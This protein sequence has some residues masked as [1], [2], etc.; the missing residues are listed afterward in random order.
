MFTGPPYLEHMNKVLF[1]LSNMR[2][3]H[4]SQVGV[5]DDDEESEIMLEILAQVSCFFLFDVHSDF[6]RLEFWREDL[7]DEAHLC[8][9]PEK[10]NNLWPGHEI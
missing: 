8:Q 9:C 2:F 5:E 6:Q 4:T 7:K 10:Y 3:A 1:P